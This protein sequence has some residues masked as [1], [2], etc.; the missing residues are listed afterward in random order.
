MVA[1]DGPIDNAYTCQGS[2]R[3]KEKC[4]QLMGEGPRPFSIA[5]DSRNERFWNRGKEGSST[6]LPG[7]AVNVHSVTMLMQESAALV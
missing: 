6:E 1:R 2:Q 4:Q 5:V 7:G 3:A